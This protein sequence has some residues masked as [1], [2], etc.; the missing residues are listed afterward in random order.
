MDDIVGSIFP[1]MDTTCIDILDE[2]TT[3]CDIEELHPLTDTEYRFL[4]LEYFLYA[5]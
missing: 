2:S 5:R 4:T 3:M 1:H